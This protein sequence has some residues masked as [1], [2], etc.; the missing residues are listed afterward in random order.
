MGYFETNGK[1]YLTKVDTA[2]TTI[3][4]IGKANPGSLGSEDKW[5]IL[6]IQ[7]SGTV[8]TF[9]WADGN[10]NFDNVW[11]NRVSLSYS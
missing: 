2:S 10:E 8:D 6:R 9:E 1:G 4:Y 11:D 7:T 3:T 5:Q